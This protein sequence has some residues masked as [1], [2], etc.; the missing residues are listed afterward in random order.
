MPSPTK[1]SGRFKG[2][3]LIGIVLLGPVVIVGAS[4]VF[5]WKALQAAGLPNNNDNTSSETNA[6][7]LLTGYATI[8]FVGMH[9]LLMVTV[10]CHAVEHVLIWGASPSCRP[11]TPSRVEA[12]VASSGGGETAFTY[13]YHYQLDNEQGPVYYKHVIPEAW[14]AASMRNTAVEQLQDGP[15]LYVHPEYPSLARHVKET[16]GWLLFLQV[17]ILVLGN[18]VLLFLVVWSV[19]WMRQAPIAVASTW[20]VL[21][22]TSLACFVAGVT[23]TWKFQSWSVQS[24][25]SSPY[26]KDHFSP[27]EAHFLWTVLRGGPAEQATVA[28]HHCPGSSSAATN[29]AILVTSDY[30]SAFV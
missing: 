6:D 3:I 29:R 7:R 13:R 26:S 22:P 8:F 10:L 9:A 16:N 14:D 21:V 12:V 28:T 15:S 5:L 30:V 17:I 11:V 18:T 24:G 2:W 20:G 27:H 4:C 25:W 19:S 23:L 1:R